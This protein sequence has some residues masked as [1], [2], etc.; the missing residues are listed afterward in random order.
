MDT[1]SET[2]KMLASVDKEIE[3]QRERLQASTR[4]S[5]E[6]LVLGLALIQ[7]LLHLQ[8]GRFLPREQLSS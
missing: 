1:D 5:K 3:N 6:M 8:T 4:W 2:E 7:I